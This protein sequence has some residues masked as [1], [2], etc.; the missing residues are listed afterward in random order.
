MMPAAEV[1]RLG[2]RALAAGRPVVI[3]GTMNR[4]LALAGR[5]MPHRI[6]LPVTDRMMSPRHK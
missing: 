1:A 6:T 3:A 5:F 2:Y 4:L